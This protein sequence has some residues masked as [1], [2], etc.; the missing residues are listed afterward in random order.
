MY[1]YTYIFFFQGLEGIP[2][3]S[4]FI[5]AIV[6][7]GKDRGGNILQIRKDISQFRKDISQFSKR[8]SAIFKKIFCNFAK[9]FRNF[10]KIFRNFAKIFRNFRK[11]ILQ[12]SLRYSA[13][14][15]KIF[16]NFRWMSPVRDGAQSFIF[17]LW[18]TPI[19]FFLKNL[20]Y[21]SVTM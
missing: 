11:D 19:P 5:L 16:R 14:F 20:T 3:W 6:L 17:I 18:W 7:L 21:Y 13:I 12:F 15:A 1:V 8:Y 10:A 9:I 4:W 2:W